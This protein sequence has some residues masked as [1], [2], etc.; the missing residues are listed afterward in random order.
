VVVVVAIMHDEKL[1]ML[2]A[3]SSSSMGAGAGAA[4]RKEKEYSYIGNG[5]KPGNG[6]KGYILHGQQRPGC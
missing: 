5:S 3:S 2:D 1:R 6:S 4:L